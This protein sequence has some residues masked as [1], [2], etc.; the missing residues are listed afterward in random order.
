M[1]VDLGQDFGSL[2]EHVTWTIFARETRPSIIEFLKAEGIPASFEEILDQL[3]AAVKGAWQHIAVP[4]GAGYSSDEIYNDILNNARPELQRRFHQLVFARADLLIFPTTPTTAPAIE[5]QRSFIVGG[6]EVTD[7]ALARNT[8]S[9]S[10]AGLPG[11][12]LPSGIS[13]AGLPLAVELDGAPGRDSQL[14]AM[15]RRIESVLDYDP[16]PGGA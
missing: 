7:L 11:I 4:G 14:L 2:N 10:S 9:A 16:W 3:G 8:I 1:E 5:S 15:A 13:T 6:K 12:S